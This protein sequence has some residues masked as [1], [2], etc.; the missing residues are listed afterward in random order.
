MTEKSKNIPNIYPGIQADIARLAET[1]MLAAIIESSDDAII[2]K[3]LE[4]IITSWN[5][6][7]EKLFGHTEAEALGKHISLIIPIERLAEEQLII[8]KIKSG[9]RLEH[10]ETIRITKFGSRIPISLTI[11]PIKNYKGQIVGASKIARDI[12]RQKMAEEKLQNY[13]QEIKVLNAKKDE[14][15]GLA[16]HE[17]KTPI[18]S[19][20]GYL[21]IIERNLPSDDRNKAFISKALLQVNKLNSLISDLLDVSKI[22]TGKLPFTYSSFDLCEVL[23]E[24]AEMLQHSYTSHKISLHFNQQ[25]IVLKA[26]Q[27]RIEQVIINLIT[28]AIKYSPG[29][30]RVIVNAAIDNNKVTVSVQDFGIGIAPEQQ[31]NIFSRFYRVENISIPVSG[32]GIGLYIS[33]EIISRHEGRLWVESNIGKGSTFYFELPAN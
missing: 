2:S 20:N 30:A 18:T 23:T 7:A 31:E 12:T 15:I 3:N 17:L 8:N 33:H 19:L 27:Q 13:A 14:F 11:S 1:T 5:K 28:N 29:G 22:Q 26:D 4:G 6:S 16:S 10:F 25:P 32:L 9:Q 24:V 21:Q